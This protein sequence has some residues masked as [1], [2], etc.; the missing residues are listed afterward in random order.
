[1]KKTIFIFM[2]TFIVIFSMT[3]S[4]ASS[5][6]STYTISQTK[7]SPNVYIVG[8]TPEPYQEYSDSGGKYY[9]R[10]RE[11]KLLH[12]PADNDPIVK[13]KPFGLLYRSS[14]FQGS[15]GSSVSIQESVS[16]S[17]ANTDSVSVSIGADLFGFKQNVTTKHSTTITKTVG[18]S[19][20]R[21]YSSGYSYGFPLSTAPANCTKA[22]R[23]VGFQVATYRS[24][25]DV[26]KQITSLKKFTVKYKTYIN[27]C[28]LCKAGNECHD[29]HDG[30]V[31]WNLELEDGTTKYIEEEYKHELVNNGTIDENMTY[32]KK[33][34][35]QWKY[36]TVIG[37][38]KLHI[39]ALVTIYYDANGNIID[40]DGNI[41]N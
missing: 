6:M 20:T 24:I 28:S 40:K 21:S 32:Y 16:R 14:N 41:V 5:P 26:K 39:E 15:L 2:L 8:P 38:V 29:A 9:L 10:V 11:S 34:V 3:L 23:G 25:I 33:P 7:A 4:I 31:G 30:R 17:V 12:G 35:K 22:E 13:Y 27:E 1:M 18:S 36:E 19:I 37:Y